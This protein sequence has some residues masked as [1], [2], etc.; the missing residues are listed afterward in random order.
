MHISI[1]IGRTPGQTGATQEEVDRLRAIV[2][3]LEG[4]RQADPDKEEAKAA[5]TS[6]Q[7]ASQ[8]HDN[9]AATT[10]NALLLFFSILVGGV[11]AYVGEQSLKNLTISDV[12]FISSILGLVIPFY[13]ALLYACGA[14]KSKGVGEIDHTDS[15]VATFWRRTVVVGKRVIEKSKQTNGAIFWIKLG[16]LCMPFGIIV[17]TLVFRG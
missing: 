3:Q 1:T 13:V 2:A 14:L 16:G 17:A 10:K 9:K 12:G 15:R 8:V 7:V 5:L 11:L 6:A 4:S